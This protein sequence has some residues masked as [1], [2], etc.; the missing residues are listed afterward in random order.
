EDK[1]E[2]GDEVIALGSPHGFQ[3]TVTLGIISGTERNFSVNGYEYTN[4]YQISAPIAQGNSGG[5]LIKRE[6]GTVIGINSV[7]TEDGS[8]G[9]SIPVR[10]V[11]EQ[12]RQWSHKAQNEQLEFA[13]TTD[14]IQHADPDQL[15]ED[16]EYL[17]EY[18]LDSLAIRD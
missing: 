1:A 17:V 13:S 5:P 9:F 12:M 14:L 2:I 7:G 18:F 4:L 10:D 11:Y 16:A 3:N 8:L 15:K 6:N